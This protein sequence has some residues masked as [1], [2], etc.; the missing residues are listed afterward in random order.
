MEGREWFA[1][2][3]VVKGWEGGWVKGVILSF[4]FSILCLG[5]WF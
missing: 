2:G 5:G 4:E 1:W 3:L